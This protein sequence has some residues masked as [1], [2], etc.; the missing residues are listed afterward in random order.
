LRTRCCDEGRRSRELVRERVEVVE[1]VRERE[2]SE[3]V[4][5]AREREVEGARDDIV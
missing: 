1:F 3:A 4:E 5:L 2:S